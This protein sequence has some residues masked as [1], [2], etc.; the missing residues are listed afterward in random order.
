MPG[1]TSGIGQSQWWGT[2]AGGTHGQALNLHYQH[3]KR[4]PHVFMKVPMPRS[5]KHGE[6][7]PP[8]GRT[9]S[10]R[11]WEPICP[12][13]SLQPAGQASSHCQNKH[14]GTAALT[15]AVRQQAPGEGGGCGIFCRLVTR[16]EA[17][18]SA[19]G[20][21]DHSRPRDFVAIPSTLLA[22]STRLSV[23]S[24]PHVMAPGV[25]MGLSISCQA[26]PSS[27]WHLQGSWQLLLFACLG[28]KKASRG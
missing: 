8:A 9:L 14:P 6:K 23:P 21:Q 24:V 20:V 7:H 1:M 11:W 25:S 28:G 3:P 10:R 5:P 16:Q 13:T 19:Q 4:C 17:S 22:T 18:C 26:L 12:T 2:R 15:F 27:C